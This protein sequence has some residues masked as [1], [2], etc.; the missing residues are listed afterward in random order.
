MARR[1]LTKKQ[2]QK[3]ARFTLKNF[4]LIMIILIL[5]VSFL[6]FAYYKGWLDGIFKSD[7][8]PL[9][10]G[11]Y[12]MSINFIDVG[13]G[14][15]III[16][17][18]DGKNMIIDSGSAKD[19]KSKPAITKFTD[20]HKITQ[21]DYMLLTH[22]DED[23]VGNMSWVIDNYDIKHIFRPNNNST[24][25]SASS[26]PESFNT[27]YLAKNEVSTLT[28]AKFMISAYNEQQNDGCIVEVFNKD[29]DFSGDVQC[30]DVT[31]KY[32]FD[33]LTPIADK[34][35]VSY[36]NKNDYS[37][38]VKLSYANKSILF[39]G[40]GE[41]KMMQEYVNTYGKENNVDVLKVGH[42]GSENATSKDLIES[43]DPE[44]AII[45]CGLGNTYG[46][47]HK[48]T[49]DTLINYDNNMTI[50]R[51][52]TNG[53]ITCTIESNGNMIFN[54]ERPDCTYN[55]TNGDNMPTN[56][57]KFDRYLSN[58]TMIVA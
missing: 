52:D 46:H 14:D 31:L 8:D 17:M 7:D 25:A 27:P 56:I 53:L 48:K 57:L 24:H 26:L 45:Q 34:D 12:A 32:A 10:N 1:K 43:I 16:L 18:P 29:S 28:Y 22:A 49:L 2:K 15:C 44:F 47:P 19:T 55:K 3:I 13:Q 6:F 35:K 30:D 4:W 9:G 40:D 54:L 5:V 33:F 36:S 58:R 41:S 38:Y 50:Y 51:N 11:G 23:H 37:P 39:T 20:A 42:H 21:F